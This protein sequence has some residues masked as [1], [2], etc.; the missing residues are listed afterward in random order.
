MGAMQQHFLPFEGCRITIVAVANTLLGDISPHLRSELRQPGFPV[1]AFDP[2]A[3]VALKLRVVFDLCS[4]PTPPITKAIRRLGRACVGPMDAF[5]ERGGLAHDSRRDCS[6]DVL[7]RLAA[8]GVVK[9]A[10][11]G[12]P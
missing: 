11:A 12:P 5:S 8:S 10:T 4:G 7:V 2:R 3:A 6:Y 9:A 1:E